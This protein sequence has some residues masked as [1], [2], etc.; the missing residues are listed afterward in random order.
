MFRR[1]ATWEEHLV[2]HVE[3]HSPNGFILS[4][5]KVAQ[6]VVP[7]DVGC[8]AVSVYVHSPFESRDIRVTCRE[9][10]VAVTWCGQPLLLPAELPRLQKEIEFQ[11]HVTYML[12]SKRDI[13]TQS[14]ANRTDRRCK[15]LCLH[16]SSASA[17]TGY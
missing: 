11:R 4:R 5:G 1:K 3:S 7:A 8:M 12:H 15:H 2:Q 17:P 6:H 13:V 9:G 14:A 16:T 10:G